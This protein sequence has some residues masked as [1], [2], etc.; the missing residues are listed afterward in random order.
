MV[1]VLES[2]FNCKVREGH[3]VNGLALLRTTE[4]WFGFASS[5]KLGFP[6]DCLF[7]HK[8]RE[9]HKINDLI[10]SRTFGSILSRFF[11]TLMIRWS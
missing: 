10:L 6:G 1:L 8:R 2:Y 11:S 7:Y 5:E 3:K 9:G 4:F